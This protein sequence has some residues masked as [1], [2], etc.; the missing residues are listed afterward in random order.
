VAEIDL[1]TMSHPHYDA[2]A[3]LAILGPRGHIALEVHDNDP[4]LGQSRWGIGAS[5]RWRGIR[6][7][8]LS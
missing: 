8:E 1:A 7:R 5:C 3:V 2:D 6:I 4:V